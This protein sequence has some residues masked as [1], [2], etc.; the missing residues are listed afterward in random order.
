MGQ[1]VAIS[2]TAESDHPAEV[3]NGEDKGLRLSP[4][5]PRSFRSVGRGTAGA[6]PKRKRPQTTALPHLSWSVSRKHHNKMMHALNGNTAPM[7]TPVLDAGD[8]QAAPFENVGQSCFINAT[9]AAILAAVKVRRELQTVKIPGSRIGDTFH[10]SIGTK[11]RRIT[12]LAFTQPPFYLG[13]QR[14]ACELLR[15]ALEQDIDT[16]VDGLISWR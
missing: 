9:L 4:S 5:R 3:R 2:S 6:M 14:G 1:S 7:G 11:G 13:A 16:R 12:P 15:E 10:A 8:A